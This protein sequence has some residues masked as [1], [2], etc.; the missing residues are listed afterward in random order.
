GTLRRYVKA[1]RIKSRRQGRSINSKLEILITAD[2]LPDG[3]GDN[4]VMDFDGEIDSTVEGTEE[5]DFQTFPSRDQADQSLDSTLNWMRQK[6]DEKDALLREKEAKIEALA[7]QLTGA[8]YRNG[9][10]EAEKSKFEEK[11]LLLEDRLLPEQSPAPLPEIPQ[12]KST[13]AKLAGWLT[14]QS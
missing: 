4:D 1:R 7:Q 13:W 14:G 5:D 8:S 6:L 12:P 9:F 3:T 11:L 10:L 2:M